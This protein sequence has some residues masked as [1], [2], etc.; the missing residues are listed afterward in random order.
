MTDKRGPEGST[1]EASTDEGEMHVVRKTEI[2]Q[3]TV[4]ENLPHSDDPVDE[5]SEDS[6]PAS[7]PPTY[8]GRRGDD[9]ST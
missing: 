9:S 5:A 8:S 1:T 4:V 2:T 3:A 7:D 6:F